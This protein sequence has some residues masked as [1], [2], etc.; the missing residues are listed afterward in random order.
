MVK[1]ATVSPSHPSRA[2]TRLFHWV[3]RSERKGR[4]GTYR[5]A[6][7]PLASIICERRGTLLLALP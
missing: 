2:K 5:A 4:G 1:K 3:G 7:E 6:L